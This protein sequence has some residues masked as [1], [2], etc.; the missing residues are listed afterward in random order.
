V[1]KYSNEYDN[2]QLREISCWNA[3]SLREMEAR[4]QA[5]W[6]ALVE[7]GKAPAWLVEWLDYCQEIPVS[8]APNYQYLRELIN[9]EEEQA[10]ARRVAQAK[11]DSA[12]KAWGNWPEE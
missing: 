1:T 8:M 5:K 3:A 4:R 10:V 6:E 2:S 11:A 12:M 9:G 7:A